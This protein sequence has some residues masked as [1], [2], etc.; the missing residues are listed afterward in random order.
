MNL[1]QRLSFKHLV[2][3]FCVLALGTVVLIWWLRGAAYLRP[4][5]EQTVIFGQGELK[6][7]PELAGPGL[8]RVVH[9][10]DRI[11]PATRRPT[12]TCAIDRPASQCRCGVL[13][14]AEAGQQ[15]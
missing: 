3:G 2:V 5:A 10:W 1:L 6:L 8:I 14:R 4:Y 7:P 13:Q 11:A 15:G 9:F 12:R